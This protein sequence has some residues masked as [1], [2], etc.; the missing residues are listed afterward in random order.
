LNAIRPS[1]PPGFRSGARGANRSQFMLASALTEAKNILLDQTT[2]Y[3][4]AKA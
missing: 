2:V 1:E 3:L 4:D